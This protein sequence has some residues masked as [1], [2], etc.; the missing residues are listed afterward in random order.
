MWALLSSAAL[1]LDFPT[2]WLMPMNIKVQAW[3]GALINAFGRISLQ[4]FWRWQ[5]LF[6]FSEMA[7]QRPMNISFW[8]ELGSLISSLGVL[9]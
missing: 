6:I 1:S 7:F 2:S 8:V 5:V 9:S 4:R 3:A